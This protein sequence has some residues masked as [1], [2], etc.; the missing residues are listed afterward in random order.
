MKTSRTRQTLKSPSRRVRRH[1]TPKE[2]PVKNRVHLRLRV[3]EFKLPLKTEL[4]GPAPA[5]APAVPRL[6]STL[7]QENRPAEPMV[8][9]GDSAFHLYIREIGETKLL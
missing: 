1:V 2:E 4:E 9:S 8:Y 6:N 3:P 7:R 5:T